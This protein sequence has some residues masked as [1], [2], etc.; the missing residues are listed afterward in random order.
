MVAFSGGLSQM[1]ALPSA[2]RILFDVETTLMDMERLS[3]HQATQS[4]ANC[5]RTDGDRF[6]SLEYSRHGLDFFPRKY[7]RIE[8]QPCR[9]FEQPVWNLID[10][11]HAWITI[12][13]AGS[14]PRHYTGL[15][16]PRFVPQT[17]STGRAGLCRNG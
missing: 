16:G 6:P 14:P 10:C 15:I 2:L 17:W 1:L 9:R 5:S 12:N 13:P 3:S 7:P 4:E 8:Q 11:L